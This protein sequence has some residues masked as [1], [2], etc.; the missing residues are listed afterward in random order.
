MGNL[1]RLHARTDVGRVREHNEDNFYCDRAL[2]LYIVADGMGGH[3]AG[4]V[5][6]ALAVQSVAWALQREK[7]LL[8]RFADDD[9]EVEPEDVKNLLAQAVATANASVHR[10]SMEN[11]ARRGMG[12]TLSA[13]LLVGRRAFIAHVGDSR[14]YIV[15]GRE[16]RQLTEDHSV[17]NELRRRGRLKPEVLDKIPNKNAITRAI[18]VFENVEVDAWQFLAAPGDRFILCSD[19]L[20]RYIDT[21]AELGSL[22]EGLTEEAATER[23][24]DFANERGGADNVTVVVVGLPDEEHPQVLA[25]LR[26]G[27]QTLSALPFFRHLEPRELMGVQAI[28]RTTVYGPGDVIIDE[29]STGE[30]L[31]VILSG[32]CAV[33]KGDTEIARL[34]PGEHF[35]EMALVELAP[36][37]ASVVAEE[38][39]RLLEIARTDLFKV[40]RESKDTGI[41]LLW[42]IITVLVARLRETSTQLGEA[43]EALASEDLTA[44][45]FLDEFREVIPDLNP[46]EDFP[47]DT[48]PVSSIGVSTLVG[49]GDPRKR[50]GG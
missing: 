44:Q 20:H 2:G 39:S 11:A 42:N 25:E 43:R 1:H 24:V 31:F 26:H 27:Y 47:R 12:T 29:G 37:S 49:Y 14:V 10:E 7:G 46:P 23:L 8:R 19:G 21:E 36:R 48:I 15:R 32:V 5:A 18:G 28:A 40:L 9:P 3:A 17:V 45:L 41:K 6:S 35:G 13:L 50:D 4:E 16:V 34:G 22:V 38:E 33:R 30:S